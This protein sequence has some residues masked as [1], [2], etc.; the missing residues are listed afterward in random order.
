MKIMSPKDMVV[1]EILNP[2]SGKVLEVCEGGRDNG[3]N[4]QIWERHGCGAQKWILEPDGSIVNP[5]SGKALDVVG[6]S[7]QNGAN[8]Q[9]YERNGTGAQKWV[10]KPDGCIMNPNSGKM[11]DVAG[12]GI[13][14]GTNVQIWEENGLGGQKWIFQVDPQHQ[15]SEEALRHI[16][17]CV[18]REQEI[19]D[20]AN[21]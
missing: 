12:G 2:Q 19:Y 16:G 20:F 18:C 8:V 10:L 17:A 6:A 13:E 11:L 1:F 3:A 7:T 15:T 5:Q 9:L 4:I 14:N 21:E